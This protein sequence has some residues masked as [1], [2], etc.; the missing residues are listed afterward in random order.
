MY[1]WNIPSGSLWIPQH[2][3]ELPVT[4]DGGLKPGTEILTDI[5]VAAAVGCSPGSELKGAPGL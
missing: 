2:G 3:W 1:K 5:E 4:F